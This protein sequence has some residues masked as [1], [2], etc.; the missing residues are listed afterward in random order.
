MFNGRQKYMRDERNHF[1]CLL[2]YTKLSNAVVNAYFEREIQQ[3]D[4][5]T[6]LLLHSP[7]T[8]LLLYFFYD[9][10]SSVTVATKILEGR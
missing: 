9:P 8:V 1:Q 6:Q 5:R 4:I 10:S 3:L 2:E 7:V